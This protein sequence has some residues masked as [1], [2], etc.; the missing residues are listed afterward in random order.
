MLTAALNSQSNNNQCIKSALESI[1]AIFSLFKKAHCEQGQ[2][3]TE[4]QKEHGA[5]YVALL[6][7]FETRLAGIDALEQCQYHHDQSVY[8]K[9]VK[10]IKKHF[11][12][13]SEQECADDPV[14]A[15]VTRIM[16]N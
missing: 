3:R 14:L 1:L 16:N 11:K 10:I 5:S 7:D 4:S 15:L 12:E 2:A 6:L 9:A 8:R 13:D